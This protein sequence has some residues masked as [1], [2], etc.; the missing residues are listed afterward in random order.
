MLMKDAATNFVR[1]NLRPEDRITL[2]GFRGGQIVPFTND[3]A[4]L[5]A[6]IRKVGIEQVCLPVRKLLILEDVV[7]YMARLHGDRS[8]VLCSIGFVYSRAVMEETVD[9][10]I[11]G[12]IPIHTLD[13][14]GAC[15]PDFSTSRL[16]EPLA[17]LADSTGGR[18]FHNNNDF[19]LGL[20]ELL[21]PPAVSYL[22][23]F[24]PDEAHDGRYHSLK[25]R[26][27][28]RKGYSIDARP[29]YF[30][31]DPKDDKPPAERP[32]DLAVRA[33]DTRNDVPVTTTAMP[34]KLVTGEPAVSVVAHIDLN[35]LAFRLLQGR[36]VQK[37]RFVAALLNNGGGF[38]AGKEGQPEF[39][40][41]DASLSDLSKNG[42]NATL[43]ISAP[44]G[45]YRVPMVVQEQDGKLTAPTAQVSIP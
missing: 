36:H 42:V 35:R 18:H 1:N 14:N 21:S 3:A 44:A 16:S 32:I 25:I 13:M 19:D 5:L 15:C 34:D 20:K 26:L 45:S 30:A 23:G 38:V 39:A 29:G 11:R 4:A 24:T 9:K 40:L 22:L 37:L 8:I 7:D 31:P 27:P 41:K 6:A 17:F 33:D 12:G 28:G 43:T 10:A 2:V